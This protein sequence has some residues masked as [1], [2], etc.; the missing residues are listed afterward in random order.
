MFKPVSARRAAQLSGFRS[1]AMLDYLQRSEVFVPRTHRTR[2]RGTGRTY[3]FRDLVILRALSNLLDSGASVAMLRGALTEFQKRKWTAD[4][5][6]LED[7]SGIVRYFV[8]NAGHVYL[9]RDGEALVD[10]T[11]GGQL[12]FSFILDLE[13]IRLDLRKRLGMPDPQVEMTF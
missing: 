4:P 10:L 13:A 5:V 11:R 3:D 8:A 9:V 6:T 7:P 2:R 1:V 12:A